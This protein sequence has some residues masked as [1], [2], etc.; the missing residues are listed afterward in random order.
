MKQTLYHIYHNSRCSKSR[1]AL[2]LLKS[3]TKNYKI[4]K[5]LEVGIDENDLGAILNSQNISKD[6]LIRKNEITFKNLNLSKYELNEN[7]IKKLI[8]TNPIL[9]QRPLITKYTG[10]LLIKSVIGRPPEIVNTLFD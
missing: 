7:D 6:E 10:G 8:I 3:K 2:E 5:Y 9:L 4:I 1:Q